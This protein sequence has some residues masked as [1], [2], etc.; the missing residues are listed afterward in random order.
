MR[1]RDVE[2]ILREEV[3]KSGGLAY[4]WVS[5]GNDGVPDRIVILPNEA[6]IFVEL[7]AEGGRLSKIQEAQINRL[8][9]LGQR[10]YVV[11][12]LEGLEAFFENVGMTDAWMRLRGRRTGRVYVKKDVGEYGI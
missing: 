4:K 2:R 10:V 1:E 7:K 8:V 6:P 11:T 3:K 9:K 5:P 12:G